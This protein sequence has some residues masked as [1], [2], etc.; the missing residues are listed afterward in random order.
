MAKKTTIK[1][2][3]PIGISFTNRFIMQIDGI[4]S[5]LIK[6]VSPILVQSDIQD[7]PNYKGLFG[8]KFFAPKHVSTYASVPIEFTIEVYDTILPNGLSALRQLISAQSIGSIFDTTLVLLDKAGVA[9]EKYIL[10]D[11]VVIW[12][13]LE[14]LNHEDTLDRGPRTITVGIRATKFEHKETSTV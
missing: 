13:E 14:Y 8:T 9:F 5:I 1:P 11:C 2:E 6:R 12:C 10:T 7:P 3:T 4:P